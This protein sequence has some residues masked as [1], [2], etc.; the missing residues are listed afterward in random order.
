MSIAAHLR[1]LEKLERRSKPAMG[2]VIVW[3]DATDP[4]PSPEERQRIED[5]NGLVIQVSWVAPPPR[6]DD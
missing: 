6:E 4:P 1:R 5:E 2:P 3:Y